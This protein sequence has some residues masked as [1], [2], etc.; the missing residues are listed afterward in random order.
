[1]VYLRKDR[2]PGG[3]SNKLKPRKYESFK[4]VRKINDNAYVV[5]LSSDMTMSKTFNVVDLH[6]Y[7]L[8]EQLYSDSNSRTSSFEERETDV[9]DQ[10][11]NG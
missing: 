11:K 4:I 8:I 1:M 7:Y 5:D 9:E 3:S 10:D 6:I 2:I